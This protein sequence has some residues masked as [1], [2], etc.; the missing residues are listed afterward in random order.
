[1]TEVH[2]KW[3]HPKMIEIL[4]ISGGDVTGNPFVKAEL[5]EQPE[6][7]GQTLFTMEPLP[8]DGLEDGRINLPDLGHCASFSAACVTPR[9]RT[10]RTAGY[11][12]LIDTLR[13]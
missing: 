4:G 11:P 2:T 6:G 13:A 10:L 5:R 12:R 1:M 9:Y 3:I 7:S 8:V